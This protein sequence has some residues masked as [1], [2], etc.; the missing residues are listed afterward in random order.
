MIQGQCMQVLLDKMKQDADWE[1]TSK[2]YDLLVLIR[3]IEKT[4]L[5]QTG[6][7]YPFATVYNQ[8]VALLGFHQNM[9]TNEQWYEHFNTKVD[10]GTAIGVAKLHPVLIEH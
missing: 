10:I 3:L 6:D 9:L 8:E 4:I 1:V 5:A 7:Q 2:L